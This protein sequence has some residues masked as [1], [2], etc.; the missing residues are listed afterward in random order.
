MKQVLLVLTVFLSFQVNAAGPRDND[1]EAIDVQLVTG[2]KIK[3]T[4]QKEVSFKDDATNLGLSI[5]NGAASTTVY[6]TTLGATSEH[7]MLRALLQVT[8]VGSYGIAAGMAGYAGYSIGNL[9]VKADKLYLDGYCIGKLSRGIEHTVNGFKKI[10]KLVSRPEK[11]QPFHELKNINFDD[12]KFVKVTNVN[13]NRSPA[14]QKEPIAIHDT[15]DMPERS[16][17][18]RE[19]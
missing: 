19:K 18:T 8:R 5:L 12:P 11:E 4:P 15:I 16:F 10:Q 13:N 9:V 6:A 2:E 14:V 17:N 7:A 1:V 3:I